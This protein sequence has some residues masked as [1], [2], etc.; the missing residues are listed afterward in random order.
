MRPAR[1]V[2]LMM[3]VLNVAAIAYHW[4]TA[5]A[6]I[7]S[8]FNG[9]GLPDGR[10]GRVEFLVTWLGIVT[11][12]PAIAMG[13]AALL[14]RFSTGSIN[15]P[16]KELWL[17]PERREATLRDL[18]DMLAWMMAATTGFMFA[19]MQGVIDAN[20]RTPARLGPWNNY[21]IVGLVSAMVLIAVRYLLHWASPPER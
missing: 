13:Y 21:A 7:W 14:P 6:V 3:V 2:L 18:A 10:S 19:V 8:H 9:A 12:L 4:Q 5:P 20:T 16:N 11:L 1:L 17:A 15:I